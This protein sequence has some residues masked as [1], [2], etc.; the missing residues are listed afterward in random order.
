MSDPLEP[1]LFCEKRKCDDMYLDKMTKEQVEAHYE[2]PEVD[3]QDGQETEQ[4]TIE[5]QEEAHHEFQ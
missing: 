5:Y 2:P 3:N 4:Q 1:K